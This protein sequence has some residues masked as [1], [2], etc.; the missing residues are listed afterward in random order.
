MPPLLTL[1]RFNLDLPST[2]LH[3]LLVKKLHGIYLRMVR[4]NFLAGFLW[5]I[6][7]S[8]PVEHEGRGPVGDDAS[9]EGCQDGRV[10]DLSPGPR[11]RLERPG[12][13]RL[14]FG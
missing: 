8:E 11:G 6:V 3:E 9:D 2:V 5:L 14:G 1:L 13:A 7:A 4:A 10:G 12:F